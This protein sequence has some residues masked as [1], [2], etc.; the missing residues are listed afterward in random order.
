M[1]KSRLQL[2]WYNKDKALIQTE[3]GKYGYMWVDPTDSRYCGGHWTVKS[4]ASATSELR[5]LVHEFVAEALKGKAEETKIA[6]LEMPSLDKLTFHLENTRT[7]RSRRKRSLCVTGST[8]VG[9]NRFLR[10]NRLILYTGYVSAGKASRYLTAYRVVAEAAP[11][12]A[13]LHLLYNP[14]Q[15]YLPILWQ[16]TTSTS[17]GLSRARMHAGETTRPYRQSAGKRSPWW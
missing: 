3:M 7:N 9:S 1:S 13:H 5:G 6:P 8:V 2:A 12:G 14:T 16:R 4:L 15:R 11:S 17:T 10:R